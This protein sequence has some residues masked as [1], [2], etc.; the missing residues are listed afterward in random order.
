MNL[1][2]GDRQTHAFDFHGSIQR[3]PQFFK[4]MMKKFKHVG[5]RVYILSGSPLSKLSKELSDAGYC[6]DLH[7]D[8]ALSVVDWIKAKGHT[9]WQNDL[10][11]WETHDDIWWPSKSQIC[12]E[13]KI[14]I[15]WDDK[16]QYF[17]H[18]KSELPLF[19]LIK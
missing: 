1:D 6:K 4:P 18:C 5:D 2:T 19:M 16:I 7:Y 11:N 14:D 15:I 8:E 10:G 17:E 3:Y 12:D 9:M 13:Y